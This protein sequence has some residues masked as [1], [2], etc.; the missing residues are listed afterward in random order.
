MLTKKN[1]NLNVQIL[2]SFIPE[3]HKTLFP[4]ISNNHKINL[5]ALCAQI[6]Q[7]Y[8]L[9]FLYF[10]F[11]VSFLKKLII[12]KLDISFYLFYYF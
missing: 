11:V 3:I 9:K 4:R 12:N 8:K 2:Y 10:L 5:F 7:N 6:L 1:L